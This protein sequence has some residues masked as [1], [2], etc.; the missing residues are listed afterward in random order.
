VP[1]PAQKEGFNVTYCIKLAVTCLNK[2]V[3]VD[4][5]ARRQ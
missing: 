2:I 4:Y 1:Y 3:D 5:D